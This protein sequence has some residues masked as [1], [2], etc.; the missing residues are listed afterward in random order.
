MSGDVLA[1]A[2]DDAETVVGREEAKRVANGGKKTGNIGRVT[3]TDEERERTGWQL[4]PPVLEGSWRGLPGAD[5]VGRQKGFGTTVSGKLLAV[6]FG[7][8]EDNVGH[9]AGATFERVYVNRNSGRF[10]NAVLFEDGPLEWRF[11]VVRA[12]DDQRPR[13][14]PFSPPTLDQRQQ[15]GV[16]EFNDIRL[17]FDGLRETGIYGRITRSIET[18]GVVVDEGNLPPVP[19]PPGGVPGIVEVVRATCLGGGHGVEVHGLHLEPGPTVVGDD[20][21]QADLPT[22]PGH[23]AG[24]GAKNEDTR[25]LGHGADGA[26]EKVVSHGQ[27]AINA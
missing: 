8:G 10:G 19:F 18:G 15:P 26:R 14:A 25:R 7:Y 23:D 6:V 9:G 2:T 17:P 4:C 11:D 27:R 22:M 1:D 20:F 21:R 13:E 24:I 3:A 12:V 16:L 5:A